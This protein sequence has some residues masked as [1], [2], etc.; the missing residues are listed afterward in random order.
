MNINPSTSTMSTT[1]PTLT[2]NQKRALLFNINEPLEILIQE[3]DNDWWPLVSNIWTGFSYRNHVN[4][5]SWKSFTCRFTKH[6]QSSLRKEGIPLEKRQKMKTRPPELCF[7]KIKVSQFISEQKVRVERYNDLPDHTYSLDESEKLKRSQVV[8]TLVEQEALKNYRPPAIVSAVKEFATEKLGLNESV[9][10]LRRKEVTNIKSKVRGSLDTH[11]IGNPNRELDIQ[12]T[13]IFLKKQGYLVERYEVIHKPTSGFV[14]IHPNQINNLEQYGWLTLIDSTHKTNRYDFRLFTL[15]IRNTYGCWDVGAH[16]FVSNKDCD[17][18]SKA[19]K[20]IRKFGNR[21]KPRYFLADQSHVEAN[22]IKIAFPGLK[23]GEQECDVIFCTV[24]VMR[25]W[26]SKIYDSKTW[27]KMIQAMHKITKVGCESIIQQAIDECPVPTIKQYIKRNFMKNTHQWALWARELKKSTSPKYG[28]IGACH[29]IVALDEKK[30]SDSEYVSFEFR[31][32]N[33]SA[34]GIDHVILHEIHKFPFPVQQMLVN[35][36]NAVQG[37]IEKGKPT[38]GLIS[39]NCNCL[40]F[41]QF[42]LPCRHI[43]HEHVYGDIKLLTVDIWEKFQKMFE[44]AGFEIYMHRELVEIEEPKK[45]EA[46]KAAENRRLTINELMERTRDIYWRVEEKNN[47]EQ[48]CMF[49]QELNTCLEPV[50]NN[51]IN[52]ILAVE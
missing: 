21:W 17:T 16:F 2:A 6:N 28:L 34:I 10:E 31:T 1:S 11:L 33:I 35:E 20:I 12:E 8:R 18:V 37:R 50:L 38:P 47:P 52:E 39:L 42:L 15:H 41:R 29:K 22:S 13:I 36:F 30:R 48:T 44:E 19:L 5:N 49:I 26:M 25:T 43:F 32:K 46:E 27:Q 24:H 3:F 45:T 4:G 23:Y 40:F 7:A 51:K 14:F 9:K